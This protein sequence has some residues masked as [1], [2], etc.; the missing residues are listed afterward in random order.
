MP[1]PDSDPIVVA[2][3]ITP[4]DAH[5]RVD[6]DAVGRNVERWLTTPLGG[7]L[8]G[9]ATGEEWF[10]SEEEKVAIVRTIKQALGGKRFVVGGIDCPS[11]TETLRRAEAFAEAGADLVRVR[12]PRYEVAVESYFEQVLAR[13]PLPAVVIHQFNPELFGLVGRPAAT[14][15][16]IGRVASMDNVFGYITD[17]DPR[18]ESQVRRYIPEDRRFWICNGSLVLFG[19]LIGCNGTNTAF[20]NVWPTALHE[21]L[22]L[23]LAGRY[24]EAR[25]L[26]A[27][28]QNIDAIMLRYGAAGVKAAL[29][30]LGYDGTRPR[31]PI[32]PMPPAD[33][34]KLET[35]MRQA[36]LLDPQG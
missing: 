23:G 24:Q 17:H 30:L 18:A 36:G 21:L 27:K 22:T 10:L 16:V 1:V 34:A 5:D 20:A 31:S 14:P 25:P 33:V 32:P 7:L 35:E 2:P 13:L 3:V 29:N 8:V 4:F 26:Q 9:S 6:H 19:T 28:I 15:K 12:I 11:V